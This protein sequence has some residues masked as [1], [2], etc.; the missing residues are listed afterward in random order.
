MCAFGTKYALHRL[1]LDRSP[2]FYSAFSEPWSESA[3]KEIT[4]HPE[5]VDPNITRAAFE[6]A[7]KRLYGCARAEEEAGEA[8]GL[9]ATGC[10]LDMEDL[11][12]ASIHLLLR[13]MCPAKLSTYIRFVTGNY[14]GKH[15]DRILAAAKA[16]LCR[17]GYE[18][19][20]RYFDDVPGDIVREIIGSDGFYVPDEW[21]RWRLAQRLFNRR[22]RVK[23]V[24]TGLLDVEGRLR[25]AR[26]RGVNFMAVRFDTVYRQSFGSVGAGGASDG[27]EQLRGV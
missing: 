13:Q 15:G 14:Y 8:I 22:L 3:A 21:D 27:L 10:W 25:K 1:L 24:E 16:M 17:E 26:P 20:L 7:L 19:P 11:V 5:D 4:L 18:M 2:F 23:A 6:L 12:E 9:F